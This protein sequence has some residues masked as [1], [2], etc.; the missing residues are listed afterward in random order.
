MTNAGQFPRDLLAVWPD[1]TRG[2]VA[3]P[4]RGVEQ[5]P[6]ELVPAKSSRRFGGLKLG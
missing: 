6:D 2:P 3:L 1:G 5:G 4:V